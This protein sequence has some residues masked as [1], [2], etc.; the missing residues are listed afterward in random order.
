MLPRF[1]FFF[2]TELIVF[3]H[4]LAIE[5]ALSVSIMVNMVSFLIVEAIGGM[6]AERGT[7][8]L[9]TYTTVSSV[10]FI[11]GLSTFDNITDLPMKPDYLVDSETGKNCEFL[12]SKP[13]RYWKAEL[14][15]AQ[16][17]RVSI[18]HRG[19]TFSENESADLECEIS[20]L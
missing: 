2:I 3:N 7:P 13:H 4:I 10:K 8:R 20:R 9:S 17:H 18:Q 14:L 15:T 6:R 19:N 16:I 11:Q 5:E 1:F 12:K